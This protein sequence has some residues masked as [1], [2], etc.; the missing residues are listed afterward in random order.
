MDR[1]W[2]P[3]PNAL[4]VVSVV[5]WLL[6]SFGQALRAGVHNGGVAAAIGS[7]FATLAIAWVLRS[8]V[9]AV[10]REPIRD[11]VISPGLFFGGAVCGLLIAVGSTPHYG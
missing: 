9:R 2:Q 7:L 6:C 8:L 1:P 3:R 11:P 4:L 10:R 5:V